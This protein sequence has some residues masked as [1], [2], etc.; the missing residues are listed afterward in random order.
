MSHAEG[1]ETGRR[2]LV[3]LDAVDGAAFARSVWRVAPAI[4]RS[5]GPEVLANRAGRR[6]G[7]L[8]PWR[9][10]WAQR[11]EE[12]ERQLDEAAF[13]VVIVADVR[14]CYPSIGLGALERALRH[15]GARDT[16]IA[17]I[18][19]W[20]DWF[21]DRGVE[22]L[23]VGPE[24]SAVL[25]NAVL[26]VADRA[27]RENGT[28]FWRWV[29]DI[30]AFMPD[31]RQAIVALDGLQRALSSAGLELHDGKT[32]ILFDRDE[33]RRLLT[34]RRCSFAAGSDVA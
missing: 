23:P 29:D 15:V 2:Q 11:C 32:R 3:R 34:R 5:M 13:P 30:V 27:L 25:A 16:D 31:R 1:S 4:E 20:H 26:A 8:L 19:T 10:A 24:P 18:L 6:P 28:P 22:G 17:P 33:A 7:D 14:R 21:R 9:P 12:I